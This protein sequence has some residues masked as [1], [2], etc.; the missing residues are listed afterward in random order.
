LALSASINSD[1]RYRGASLGS[2]QPAV[3]VSV[4]YDAPIAERLDGYFAGAATVGQFP[5]AG[6]QASENTE[7]IGIAGAAGQSAGC[8]LGLSNI[9]L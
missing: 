2:D 3:T 8:D 5:G 1:Y 9:V 4:A 7:S 6:L